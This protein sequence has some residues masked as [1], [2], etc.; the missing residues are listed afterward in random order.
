M[1]A[2]LRRAKE[3]VAGPVP[4]IGEAPDVTLRLPRGLFDDGTWQKE[5][6]VRE[7]TGADEEILAKVPD[8][9]AFFTTVIALG[10][11][12]IGSI[13]FAS[14]SVVERKAE[15]GDLLLGERDMLFL[16]VAQTS[17][18][19]RKDLTFTCTLCQ[20][21][22]DITLILSE[23]FKPREVDDL[24]D[25]YSFSTS[26]GDVLEYRPAIGSDQEEAVGRKGATLAEQNTIMLSRCVTKRNG[27]L[28]PDPT[29]FVRNLGIRDRQQMLEALVKCQPSI[30]LVVKT[31][32]AACGGEQ[33][34]ALGWQDIFR[35]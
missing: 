24:K 33:T 5:V 14:M 3:A 6:T 1:Q 27:E 12:S 9:L 13:D 31:N 8:Q 21:E 4:I 32:C 25:L 2:E 23:D 34:L 10:V 22:Q 29:A 7:L 26:K 17:F 20:A 35:P 30:E 19:D 18:G 15:L 16:K 28:I 11:E